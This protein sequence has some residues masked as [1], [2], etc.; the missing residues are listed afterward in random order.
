M[1][2][3]FKGCV[4]K[5]GVITVSGGEQWDDFVHLISDIRDV[6]AREHLSP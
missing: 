4:F 3:L 5:P 6:P 2:W 1:H